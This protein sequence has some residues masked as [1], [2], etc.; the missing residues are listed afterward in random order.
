M[1]YF[2]IIAIVLGLLP[3]LITAIKAIEEA[4]PGTGKG[5]QKLAAIR[6]IIESVD[7]SAKDLWPVLQKVI[8]VLVGTFNTVGIF[9]TKDADAVS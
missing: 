7:E 9:A 8:G 2:N 6:R 3:A 4:I 1:K 5:E